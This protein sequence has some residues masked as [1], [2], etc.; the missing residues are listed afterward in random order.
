MKRELAVLGLAGAMATFA[1]SAAPPTASTQNVNIQ[2]SSISVPVTAPSALPVTVSGTPNVTVANGIS[3]PVN[4]AVVNGTSYAAVY[5]SVS[6][7]SITNGS[8]NAYQVFYTNTTS[9]TVILTVASIQGQ[10]ACTYN[11]YQASFDVGIVRNVTE[12]VDIKTRVYVPFSAT[13][14]GGATLCTYSANLPGPLVVGP[15]Y[16]VRAYAAWAANTGSI[17]FNIGAAGYTLP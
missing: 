7:F 10:A 11:V 6:S 2:S 13:N 16:S 8:A 3:N 17:V 4:V 9:S 5:P 12:F 1:V 14:W 15:G